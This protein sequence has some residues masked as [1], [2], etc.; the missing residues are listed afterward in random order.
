MITIVWSCDLHV[1]RYRL[2][3][4]DP[5]KLHAVTYF[6]GMSIELCDTMSCM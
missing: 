6:F 4:T 1:I 5:Y 3:V 2:C